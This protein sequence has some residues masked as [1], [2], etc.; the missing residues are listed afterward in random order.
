MSVI[1]KFIPEN[2]KNLSSDEREQ[3]ITEFITDLCKKLKIE[4]LKVVFTNL[5]DENGLEYGGKFIHNPT[6]IAINEKFI[7]TDNEIPFIR[8]QGMDYD[9]GIPYFLVH[10]M[11]HECYHYY[12]F[13]LEKKL[14]DD[15]PHG[16]DYVKKGEK[17]FSVIGGNLAEDKADFY[18][19]E[20]GYLLRIKN[21]HIS[22][23]GEEA[24]ILIRDTDFING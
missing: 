8:D 16:F 3:A 5:T 7:E 22:E 17:M 6:C 20:N 1:K 9:V 12:Q 4:P 2:Y 18:C 15:K 19:P 10:A 11:A 23:I 14:I 24:A 21:S 13:C